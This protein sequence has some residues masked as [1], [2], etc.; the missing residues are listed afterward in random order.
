MSLAMKSY[1]ILHI[2]IYTYIYGPLPK[3]CRR[4]GGSMGYAQGVCAYFWGVCAGGVRRMC[5]GVC[6]P[7]SL[8]LWGPPSRGMR[9]IG[10]EGLLSN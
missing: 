8:L 3:S 1:T 9:A 2:Y 5:W 6:A 4:G 10:F 7:S